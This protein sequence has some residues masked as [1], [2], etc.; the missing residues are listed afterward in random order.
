MLLNIAIAIAL[1][2]IVY[3]VTKSS[4]TDTIRCKVENEFKDREESLSLKE[5]EL[6]KRKILIEKI[7]NS[8]SEITALFTESDKVVSYNISIK[9]KTTTDT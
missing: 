7:L 6:E 3:H 4:I 8:F 1:I 5:S 2:V 9:R